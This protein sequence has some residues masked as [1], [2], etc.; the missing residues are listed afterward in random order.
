MLFVRGFALLLLLAMA[1]LAIDTLA[2]DRN[3]QAAIAKRAALV[4]HTST[5]ISAIDEC[6]TVREGECARMAALQGR[7][8]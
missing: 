2:P 4:A 5:R 3:L 8:P 1:V 7:S 6:G